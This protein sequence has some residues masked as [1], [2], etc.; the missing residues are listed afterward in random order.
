[1][2]ITY[3]TSLVGTGTSWVVWNYSGNKMYLP[4]IQK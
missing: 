1:M 2:R 3:G 4:I